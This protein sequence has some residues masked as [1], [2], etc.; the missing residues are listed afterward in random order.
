MKHKPPSSNRIQFCETGRKGKN[1]RHDD[2][3]RRGQSTSFTDGQA[4]CAAGK[5]K[6]IAY[7][8]TYERKYI[9]Q[10]EKVAY[11]KKAVFIE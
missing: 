11:C 4:V 5:K 1:T 10:Y 8:S 6:T 7:T 2:L 9:R 3:S